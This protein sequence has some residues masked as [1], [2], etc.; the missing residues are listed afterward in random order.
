MIFPTIFT[1]QPVR[2]RNPASGVQASPGN[3]LHLSVQSGVL[4]SQK[5]CG[6]AIRVSF[7]PENHQ[8][9]RTNIP[10]YIKGNGEIPHHKNPAGRGAWMNHRYKK[11]GTVQFHNY[12]TFSLLPIYG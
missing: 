5:C 8:P 3:F 10:S 12:D 11:K 7:N 9:G 1:Q 4:F 6:T 2:G